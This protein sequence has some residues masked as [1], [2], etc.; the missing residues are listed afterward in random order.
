MIFYSGA[1]GLLFWG[2]LGFSASGN[3][4][5]GGGRLKAALAALCL[6]ALVAGPAVNK[7][8]GE[9]LSL[10]YSEARS[11]RSPELALALART[12]VL[13]NPRDAMA[14]AGEG[15]A[16]AAAGDLN[17]AARSF[18]RALTLEP[19]Y[20]SARLGLV[21]VHA[22][23]GRNAQACAALAPLAGSPP[24]TSRGAYQRQLAAFDRPA[25]ERFKE[26]LCRKKTTGAATASPRRKP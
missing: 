22:A 16:R 6:A 23:A 15:A 11:G 10:A 24:K 5:G 7:Y 12:A 4:P 9:R 2:S 25:A 18:E 26:E 13:E 1:V 21:R 19:A 8:S 20:A 3:N 17:G 14:A